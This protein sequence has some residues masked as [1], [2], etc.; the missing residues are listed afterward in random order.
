MKMPYIKPVLVKR[1]VLSSIT[2]KSINSD[3]V[4]N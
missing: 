3:A 1:E 2:A 4:V